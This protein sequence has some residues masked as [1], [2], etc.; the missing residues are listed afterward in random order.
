MEKEN[1]LRIGESDQDEEP[2]DRSE[3][4]VVTELKLQTFDDPEILPH[5]NK[6]QELEKKQN[7]R[8]D[9]DSQDSL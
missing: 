4:Q 6:T 9:Q 5:I 7:A 8:K 2:R 3:A 1:S